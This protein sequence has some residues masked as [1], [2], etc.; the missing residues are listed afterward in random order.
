[1]YMIY[2]HIYCID[3][4]VHIYVCTASYIMEFSLRVGCGA[5]NRKS[6]PD[7]FLVREQ[8]YYI[9]TL[10]LIIYCTSCVYQ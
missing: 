1:M 10:F 7:K 2:S 6:C 9:L 5:L 4:Y 8:S 3:I